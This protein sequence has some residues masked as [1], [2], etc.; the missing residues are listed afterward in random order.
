MNKMKY[1]V[2]NS[3]KTKI[4]DVR[5]DW[6]PNEDWLAQCTVGGGSGRGKQTDGVR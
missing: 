3:I 4:R 1:D 6:Q 2:K 5:F